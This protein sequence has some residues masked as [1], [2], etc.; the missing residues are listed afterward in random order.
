MARVPYTGRE[1]A[2]PKVAEMFAKMEAGGF[3]LLNLYRAIGHCGEL[4]PAF[5]RLGN[6]ILFQGRL[7]PRLRELAIL[8]VGHLAQAP[9]ETSKH[10]VIGREAGLSPAQLEALPGWRTSGCF[11][12][13]ERA[14]LAYADEVS[15]RYRAQD[16]TFAELRGFLDTEQI[17]E[18]TVVI[19]FY[20]MV[21]RVLEA[22][23]IELETD[24]FQPLGKAQ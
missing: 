12:A 22:L 1:T 16:A 19:G 13:Q 21:C 5:I 11:D 8:W 24:E 17:V 9:Y 3:Q 4:G 7:P 6:K 15:R 18:L 10:L 2:P 14:V 23:Q 20:E